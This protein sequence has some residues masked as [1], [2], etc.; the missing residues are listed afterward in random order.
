[1]TVAAHSRLSVS[2]LSSWNWTLDQ[3]LSFWR[4]SGIDH[5]GIWTDKLDGPG[6]NEAVEKVAARGL[7]VSNL[8]SAG[9]FSLDR[10]A[11][12][13]EQRERLISMLD[14]AAVIEA[15]QL[16][17]TTGPANGLD[18]EEAAAA[19]ESA[20]GPVLDLGHE[21]P[22]A[23]EHT[24][25]LRPDIGFL[26]TLADAIDFA[27]QLGVGVCMECNACWAERGLYQTIT[28]GVELLSIV[29]VDDFVV[30]TR[31]TP[32][33]VV[34]GDGDIPLERIVGHLVAA[35]YKGDFDLEVVGPRIEEEGYG[36]AI[37]RSV[38]AMTA[39]LEKVN[40]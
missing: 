33:R 31:D 27:R 34:P 3:D 30:G 9:P 5:V 8:I 20:I 15:P 39:I 26:H 24:N 23:F 16:V 18:W 13:P 29:Q 38:E 1:M 37:I 19:L 12:W 10:P 22:I 2:A 25:S 40:A 11:K 7:R 35:G 21:I 28:E 14:A 17:L 36:A 32:N 6:W 4:E